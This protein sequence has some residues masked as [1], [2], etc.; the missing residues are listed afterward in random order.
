MHHS[1]DCPHSD[2]PK[3]EWCDACLKRERQL[4]TQVTIRK[5]LRVVCLDD[6]EYRIDWFKNQVSGIVICRT[7]ADLRALYAQ[8][9]VWD[10]LFLDHDRGEEE[11][12]ADAARWLAQNHLVSCF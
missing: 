2:L 8:T 7:A 12:G 3:T 6:D 9:P 1:I 10:V 11:T 4:L 5:G